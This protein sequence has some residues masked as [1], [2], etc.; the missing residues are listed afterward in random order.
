MATR[1]YVSAY[2]ALH[3]D[4]HLSAQCESYILTAACPYIYGEDP[5]AADHAAR[6]AWASAM[7]TDVAALARA[8]RRLAIKC[9][10][11]GTVLA[12]IAGGGTAE[13]SDVEY[14]GGTFL[15]LLVSLGA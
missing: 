9:V 7:E 13:D 10:Q 8:T 12:A 5:G 14:V 2:N 6:V 3:V 1:N 15:S 4:G 11:N